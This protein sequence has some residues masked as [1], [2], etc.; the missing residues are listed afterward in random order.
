[1]VSAQKTTFSD[2]LLDGNAFFL[3]RGHPLILE[4]QAF[5][6]LDWQ[7]ILVSLCIQHNV[8]AMK[9]CCPAVEI[10]FNVLWACGKFVAI[11]VELPSLV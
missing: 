8:S 1:M 9:Q 6:I 11:A 2:C 3:I 10:D 4:L 7:G 5:C